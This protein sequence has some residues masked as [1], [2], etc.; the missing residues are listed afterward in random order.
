MDADSVVYMKNDKPRP[1]ILY[2]VLKGMV[3]GSRPDVGEVRH[4]GGGE[5]MD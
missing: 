2:E 5:L 4:I 3:T 1:V